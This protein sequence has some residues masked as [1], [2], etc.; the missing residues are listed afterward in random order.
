L[1]EALGF[2][3][4]LTPAY[5]TSRFGLLT[6]ATWHLLEATSSCAT[7][8]GKSDFADLAVSHVG[9]VQRARRVEDQARRQTEAR[10]SAVAVLIAGFGRPRLSPTFRRRA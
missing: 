5:D 4:G 8:A 3:C 7:G 10:G 1:R 9:N 6:G 2:A